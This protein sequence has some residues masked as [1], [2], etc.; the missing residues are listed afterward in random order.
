MFP[1]YSSHQWQTADHQHQYPSDIQ[2]QSEHLYGQSSTAEW[3]QGHS[4]S[5]QPSITRTINLRK[6]YKEDKTPICPTLPLQNHQWNFLLQL[7][8]PQRDPHLQVVSY[9][10]RQRRPAKEIM[11][12]PRRLRSCGWQ[13]LY[14]LSELAYIYNRIALHWELNQEQQ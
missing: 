7:Q 8:I 6:L 12:R 5:Y 3:G 4:I 11:S 9:F 14:G 13:S 1:P 2:H 10:S